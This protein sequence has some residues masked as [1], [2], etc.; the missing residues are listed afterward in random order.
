MLVKNSDIIIL[1]HSLPEVDM[2]VIYGEL[3]AVNQH[4]TINTILPAHIQLTHE[5]YSEL[6]KLE[7]S[8]QKT[9]YPTRGIML[10]T[11]NPGIHY[12]AIEHPE[13]LIFLASN[14]NIDAD[15]IFLASRVLAKDLALPTYFT[16]YLRLMNADVTY[17]NIGLLK[18]LMTQ[19]LDSGELPYNVLLSTV[20]SA[21]DTVP[22]PNMSILV[23]L[24]EEYR[25]KGAGLPLAD[26]TLLYQTV[27]NRKVEFM[28]WL[29]TSNDDVYRSLAGLPYSWAIGMFGKTQ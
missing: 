25:D 19:L 21:L 2:A 7:T 15:V 28:K 10:A 20:V 5:Q 13:L 16:A 18:F 9:G 8:F 17:S 12:F 27:E 3:N 14:V 29:E 26:V 1:L 4:R 6:L 24:M 11:D 23:F 22:N